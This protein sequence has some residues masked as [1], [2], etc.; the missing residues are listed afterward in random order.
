MK[1]SKFS[2]QKSKFSLENSYISFFQNVMA[3]GDLKIIDKSK[4]SGT[5]YD[6]QTE[7]DR[8]AQYC[9][10]Q[11]LQRNFQNITI[12]GEEVRE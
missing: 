6:P 7:A 1:N 10:V 4:Q 9:I 5:G 3:G 11:S 12:I 8:R 2:P